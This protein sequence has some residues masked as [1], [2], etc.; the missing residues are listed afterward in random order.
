M[1]QRLG[2]LFDMSQAMNR[3]FKRGQTDLP[4]H[5]GKSLRLGQSRHDFFAT[6]DP[7]LQR[8]CSDSSL[9]TFFQVQMGDSIIFENFAVLSSYDQLF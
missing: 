8:F 5:L 4:K 2:L 7:V 9:P 3:L 6:D 1:L